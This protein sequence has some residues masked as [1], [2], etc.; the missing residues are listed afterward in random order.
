MKKTKAIIRHEVLNLLTSI[1]MIVGSSRMGQND[2]NRI[3]QL[4]KVIG[5][6]ISHEEVIA[7][8]EIRFL[9]EKFE[10]SDVLDLVFAINESLLKQHKLVLRMPD[11]D[12]LIN[13]D[14]GVIKNFIDH[15]LVKLC[16]FASSIELLVDKANRMLEIRYEGAES[17]KLEDKT[18]LA[19]L[20]EKRNLVDELPI[21]LSIHLMYLNGAKV[22][23]NKKAIRITFPS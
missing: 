3:E 19:C 4:V 21:R 8:G 1:N 5:L 10:L 13:A 2:K 11:N 17:L 18:L 6:L 23:F 22:E 15:T 14:K 20:E 7:G 16:T 9:N 12:F